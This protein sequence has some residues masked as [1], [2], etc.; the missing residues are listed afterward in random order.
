MKCVQ[1]R[2][3]YNDTNLGKNCDKITGFKSLFISIFK[4]IQQG[5]S[6]RNFSLAPQTFLLK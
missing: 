3:K 5:M 6:V 4:M 2:Q 1:L